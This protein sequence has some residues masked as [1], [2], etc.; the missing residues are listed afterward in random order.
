[1]A[2]SLQWYRNSVLAWLWNEAA[3][4]AI[5][6][7]TP[8]FNMFSNVNT[9]NVPWMD[10]LDPTSR[11][12]QEYDQNQM[13]I[14]ALNKEVETWLWTRIDN[15]MSDADKQNYLNHLS[16]SQYEQ[17]LKYKNEWYGFMASKALLENQYKLADTNAT[18]LMKYK[19]YA[20]KDA[21]YTQ[22]ANTAMSSVWDK[23]VANPIWQ[24][25]NYWNNTLWYG[26][27]AQK[28]NMSFADRFANLTLWN[29]INWLDTYANA[30]S[31]ILNTTESWWKALYDKVVKGY[32]TDWDFYDKDREEHIVDEVIDAVYGAWQSAMW[33]LWLIPWALPVTAW[34][35]TKPWE[36]IWG[37]TL[38]WISQAVNWTLDNVPLVKQAYNSL[39]E[40]SRDK[41]STWVA[42]VI[43]WK[44]AKWGKAKLD[45]KAEPYIRT[46]KW[47]LDNWLKKAWEYAQVQRGFEEFQWTKEVPYVDIETG[48]IWSVSE[49]EW[50]KPWYRGRILKEAREWFKEWVK[51]KM[52]PQGTT[53]SEW[54]STVYQGEIPWAE[55]TSWVSG[56]GKT[57]VNGT[58]SNWIVNRIWTA[59][60]RQWN[61]MN[62]G[63]AIKF[64]NK[65]GTDYGNWLAQRWFNQ[66]YDT[67]IN[68]LTSYADY[69]QG[70]KS[71]VLWSMT[72]RYTDPAIQEMLYDSIQKAEYIKS[73]ELWKLE[74]LAL[75]YEEWGLTLQDADWLRQRFWY[76]FPLRFDGTDVSG[77]VARNNNMYTAMREFLERKA[78]ENWFPQLRELNREIA[79]THHII[80]ATTRY[81]NG[82][83]TNDTVSLKDL[84][85][86]AWAMA[87]PSAWP[88]FFIQQA[89]KSAKVQDTILSKL[90][91]GK[92]NS[93]R[94]QI[95]ID[96]EKIKKIQDEAEQRRMLEEWI[97]KWN[98]KVEEATKAMQNRLPETVQGGVVAWER[99]F[100]TANPS[101]PTYEQMWLQEVNWIR[102]VNRP[103]AT[104]E[105]LISAI[106]EQLKEMNL[107]EGIDAQVVADYIM[108][109]LS[110]E[111]Q[112]KLWYIAEKIYNW[113]ALTEEEWAIVEKLADVIRH[114][115]DWL[116]WGEWLDNWEPTGYTPT[117]LPTN[118]TNNGGITEWGN[119]WEWGE[120]W[121]WGNNI[122][123]WGT[124]WGGNEGVLWENGWGLWK[125]ESWVWGSEKVVEITDVK[126]YAD[127]LKRLLKLEEQGKTIDAWDITDFDTYKTM[128]NPERSV[129]V[130]VDWDWKIV[131]FVKGEDA[132]K[133]A[134]EDLVLRALE[135]WADKI[136]V[137]NAA[138]VEYFEKFWF[139][140]VAWT[141][142]WGERLYFLAHNWDPVDIVKDNIWKY[143]HNS[144]LWKLKWMTYESWEK[145]VKDMLDDTYTYKFDDIEWWKWKQNY[146]TF[147]EKFKTNAEIRDYIKEKYRSLRGEALPEDENAYNRELA[148]T[149]EI[150]NWHIDT[151]DIGVRYFVGK[152]ALQKHYHKWRNT[153]AVF[154]R[155]KVDISIWVSEW[156][157][158]SHEAAHWYD[159]KLWKEITWK[160]V[161]LTD[162]AERIINQKLKRPEI[163][164]NEIADLV[165]DF[166]DLYKRIKKWWYDWYRSKS[167]PNYK[168]ATWRNWKYANKPTERFARRWE[169]F[170]KAVRGGEPTGT[171]MEQFTKWLAMD[172]AKWLWKV[173]TVRQ[174]WMLSDWKLNP[175]ND[176]EWTTIDIPDVWHIWWIEEFVK[177]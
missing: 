48:E 24:L 164:S 123:Q 5:Q 15:V 116:K 120:P 91:K 25:A 90:I 28:G 122:E 80:E 98:L 41:L 56:I 45:A 64:S 170:V 51:E 93:E 16:N 140:P 158:V 156:Y 26:E 40:D 72:Q 161:R 79:A 30:E 138:Q 46:A 11:Q 22:N 61:K 167:Y 78:A 88:L 8:W 165:W 42:M 112:A 166:V 177:N 133:W 157:S 3:Q 85:T 176:T 62:K 137:R 107:V 66:A 75:K 32:D 129:L 111:A 58:Q 1:M 12:R 154:D 38:G 159:Y 168:T 105:K 139:K 125:S 119:P 110:P 59:Q 43:I 135:E 108:K 81:Y 104:P 82:I 13:R 99:G 149:R 53:L 36:V 147:N 14:D 86:L 18:W 103:A 142:K 7:E 130:S 17:M 162:L 100:P 141:R 172:F 153:N 113:L 2:W 124:N 52:N 96:L 6:S 174:K 87:N 49:F 151:T 73:P 76:N 69:V 145:Y 20:E 35:S 9:S 21:Y 65:Y 27:D 175:I 152:K 169:A 50:F 101:A 109:S 63:Q 55:Q 127:I 71:T 89:L 70:Q 155:E 114:E 19:D 92:T 117:D 171:A 31:R 60:L 47:M 102:E 121:R 150:W 173:D 128:S 126:E 132:P 33:G 77:V 95:K 44:A 160:A 57:D 136:E 106:V 74:S 163:V 144:K 83:A 10:I 143:E 94:N 148:E 115:Q 37:L 29:I 4:Q 67:N 134:A 23:Y 131:E 34:L 118:P 84:V 97:A 146:D 68:A 39:S 54:G